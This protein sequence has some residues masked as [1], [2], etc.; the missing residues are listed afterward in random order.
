MLAT[1]SRVSGQCSSLTMTGSTWAEE[2]AVDGEDVQLVRQGLAWQGE[3]GGLAMCLGLDVFVGDV[4]IASWR[5]HSLNLVVA[6]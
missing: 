4:L 2:R 3:V 1:S 6:G 5:P